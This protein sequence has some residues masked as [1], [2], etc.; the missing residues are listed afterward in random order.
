M[1][2]KQVRD[3]EGERRERRNK[4]VYENTRGKKH[5]K[6]RVRKDGRKEVKKEERKEGKEVG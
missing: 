1:R 3:G 2:R 4:R 5:P 6:S